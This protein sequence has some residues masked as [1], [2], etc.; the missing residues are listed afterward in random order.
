MS[1]ESFIPPF[2]LSEFILGPW[3]DM[4]TESFWIFL[5][6]VIVCT[7]CG[8]VGAFIVLRRMA[9]VG[10]AISHS[11]LPGIVIAFLLTA[12]R[13]P[14][15]MMG[16][17]VVA[18]LATVVF[19]EAVHRHSRIKPDAAIGI[20]FT[21]LFAVGV[22]LISLYA[23][24]V[25]I[26]ADCVLYGNIEFV[27]FGHWV[28]PGEFGLAPEPVVQMAGVLLVVVILLLV[29]YKELL[30]TSF[31]PGL[32]NSLGIPTGVYH[33]GL[34]IMLS[35][36]IVSAFESVGAILVIA[37]LI[38]PATTGNL[39][40]DRLPVVLWLCPVF[41]VFYALGGLHLALWLNCS[42]A[43]AMVVAASLLFGFAWFF[44]PHK[45]LINRWLRPDA[46]ELAEG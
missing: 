1:A 3:R 34:M 26:D 29:F 27:T 7:A 41:S 18:G 46:E 22:I 13:D 8:L 15:I 40:S 11:L 39:F 12:S 31:D 23:G 28:G 21:A 25:H 36:V 19:I 33:Y 20:V 5:M 37:M 4:P 14:F 45:G 38:F 32:A 42:I 35:L 16:G 6:G 24:Q 43:G 44:A 10:D 17:A 2:S 9:L 30:V